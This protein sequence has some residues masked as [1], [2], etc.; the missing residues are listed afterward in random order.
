MTPGENDGDED[1]DWEWFDDSRRSRTSEVDG[2]PADD[3]TQEVVADVLADDGPR[4]SARIAAPTHA[5]RQC[6]CDGEEHD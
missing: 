1:Y 3:V 2:E 6:P 4:R 5:Y